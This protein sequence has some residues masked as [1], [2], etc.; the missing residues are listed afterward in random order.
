MEPAALGFINEL[1]SPF[2]DLDKVSPATLPELYLIV[3]GA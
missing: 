2:V 1:L 3:D